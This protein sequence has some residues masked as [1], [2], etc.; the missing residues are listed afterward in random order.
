MMG[1]FNPLLVGKHRK[2]RPI[3]A[4]VIAR[5]MVETAK[6]GLKGSH[7]FESDQIQFFYDRMDKEPIKL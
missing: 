3:Q 4:Q 1:L 2:Y 6:I 7:I 5:A